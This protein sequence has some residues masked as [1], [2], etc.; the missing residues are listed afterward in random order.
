MNSLDREREEHRQVEVKTRTELAAVE[1]ARRETEARLR[2]NELADLRRYAQQ[3]RQANDHISNA[4]S[5]AA[6]AILDNCKPAYRGWEWLFLRGQCE[7]AIDEFNMNSPIRA[8]AVALNNQLAVSVVRGEV[9]LG[10]WG[11]D[12]ARTKPIHEAEQRDFQQ[13]WLS[14]DRLMTASTVRRGE[15]FAIVLDSHPLVGQRLCE[16]T[17]ELLEPGDVAATGPA[18]P[19]L[20]PDGRTFVFPGQ[21]STLK[22]VDLEKGDVHTVLD[23]V[24]PLTALAF[25]PDGSKLVAITGSEVWSWDWPGMSH[26]QRHEVQSGALTTMAISEQGLLGVVGAGFGNQSVEAGRSEMETGREKAEQ[27]TSGNPSVGVRAVTKRR[28]RY[29]RGN[30]HCLDNRRQR[31]EWPIPA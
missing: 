10:T 28:L 15:V 12:L 2:A 16:P 20:S 30:A 9:H 19:V 1:L 27:P 24:P 23:N 31:R 22:R 29:R 13:M 7:G 4:N 6:I 17:R 8:I 14:P 26:L 25:L 3:L 21:A 5:V 18:T 11:T